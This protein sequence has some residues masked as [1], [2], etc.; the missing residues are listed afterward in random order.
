MKRTILV[1]AVTLAGCRATPVEAPAGGSTDR[2]RVVLATFTADADVAAGRLEIRTTPTAEGRSVRG[3]LQALDGVVTVANKVVGG[4]PATFF[5]APQGAGRSCTDSSSGNV[6]GATVVVTNT[7]TDTSL[8]GVYAEITSAEPPTELAS[9]NSVA[10]PSGWSA[11]GGLWS[12]PQL[13]PGQAGEVT[14]VFRYVTASWFTFSGRIV[15]TRITPADL[16]GE[17]AVQRPVNDAWSALTAIVD[18]GTRLAVATDPPG[19]PFGIDFVDRSSGAFVSTLDVAAR[20]NAM[21]VAGNRIWF[22]TDS[23]GT[24]SRVGF[25]NK[26]GTGVASQASTGFGE[27]VL[28]IVAD[29]VTPEGKAWVLWNDASHTYFIAPYVPG[30]GMGEAA[31]T[32]EGLAYAM[33]IGS[34]GRLYVANTGSG[35]IDVF[36]LGATAT[37]VESYSGG[38]CSSPWMIVSGPGGKVYFDSFEGWVCSYSADGTLYEEWGWVSAETPRGLAVGAAGQIWVST[39]G[40]GHVW[41]VLDASGVTSDNLLVATGTDVWPLA[42]DGDGVLWFGDS[43]GLWKLIP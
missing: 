17:P 41:Q 3:A 10:A 26:D 16:E 12:Y 29:P 35:A 27:A 30:V 39:G 23:D 22:G 9:C 1:L 5:N 37:F 13:G 33:T 25:V 11:T 4:L 43:A 2:R 15:G 20:V 28:A 31:V 36:A 40:D 14:W 7:L 24:T 6:W 34:D 18:A 21:S 19:G 32:P 42:V 38:S 8:G